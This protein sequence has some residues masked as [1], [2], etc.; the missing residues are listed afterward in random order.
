MSRRCRGLNPEAQAVVRQPPWEEQSRS[1][2]SWFVA[3]AVGFAT[4]QPA[5][6]SKMNNLPVPQL[7]VLFLRGSTGAGGA[8]AAFPEDRRK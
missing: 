1:V 8:A 2:A 6:K 5:D 4:W 7:P 3:L